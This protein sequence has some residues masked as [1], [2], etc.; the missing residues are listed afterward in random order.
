MVFECLRQYFLLFVLACLIAVAGS[1]D[2]S[3]SYKSLKRLLE[4]LIFFWAVN[5]I[6]SQKLRE[7]LSLILI[8]SATISTL[9][10][11]YSLWS[12]YKPDWG[13]WGL[14]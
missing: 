12:N 1:V 5:C 9:M 4:I 8:V 13:P 7:H 6:G 10:G 2:I 3:E 14:L 11:F